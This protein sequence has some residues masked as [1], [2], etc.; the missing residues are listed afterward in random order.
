MKVS[1]AVISRRSMRAFTDQPVPLETLTRVLETARW[2]PSGCNFQPWRASI[3][4]G[5]PL[6]ALQAKMM[7][8]EPQDPI[9][10]SFSEPNNSPPHLA[11]LQELGA[12]LYGAMGIERE[13]KESR[14]AFTAANIH[15]FGAPAVLFCHFERFMGPPQWSDV[16]MWLQTI[17]LLLREEGL[18]SCPQEWMSLFARVIKEHIGVSD[19][20]DILF[21][22][23]A[24]GYGNPEAPMNRFERARVP[25][26]ESVTFVGF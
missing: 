24:I 2:T 20:T 26:S 16:G 19:E 15:S 17:M 21:C 4:T 22:G 13:D 18:D 8:S 11:R 10:Y 12:S 9:E 3:L 25:L 7:A 14:G 23:L 5:E 6:K 1:D